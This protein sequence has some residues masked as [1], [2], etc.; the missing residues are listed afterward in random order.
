MGWD[1]EAPLIPVSE[2][3]PELVKAWR[4]TTRKQRF[5]IMAKVGIRLDAD[6]VAHFKATGSGWHGRI[7]DVLRQAVFGKGAAG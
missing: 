2:M 3:H 1:D 6:I 7:N 5:P 4:R